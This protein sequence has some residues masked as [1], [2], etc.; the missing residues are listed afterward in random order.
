[1]SEHVSTESATALTLTPL[2]IPELRTGVWTRFGANSVLGD[3]VTE[4]TLSTLAESTRT[5]ARSQGYS[6]GWAEGQRAA[7]EAARETGE[8]AEADRL[9]AEARRQAEH[10]E[11]VAT[12]E[13]AAAEVR[14]AIAATCARIEEQATEVAWAIT[15]E[16]LG[17]ELAVADSADVVRRV[18]ALLP[19]EPVLRVRLNPADAAGA[20]ETGELSG[21]GVLVVADPALHR[22]DAL[23]EAQEHVLDLRI[24]TALER[25]REVLR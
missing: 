24:D 22:G 9:R 25:V 5:A 4:Q 8:L 11:A 21:Q 15:Q 19:S 20:T 7:R 6:V 10:R 12:L 18:L 23:I 13:L 14:D 16:L 17:R 2:S 3:T 1:M